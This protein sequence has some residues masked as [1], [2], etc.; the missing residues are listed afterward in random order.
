MTREEVFERLNKVF[1]E[2][3]DDETIEVNDDTTSEVSMTGILL[4][5]SI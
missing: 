5:I 2:V 1:Q 3:F 4:N